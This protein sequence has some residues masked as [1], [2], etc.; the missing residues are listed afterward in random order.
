MTSRQVDN[1]EI[2]TGEGEQA[3]YSD[4]YAAFFDISIVRGSVQSFG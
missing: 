4:R 3:I 1:P 2:E